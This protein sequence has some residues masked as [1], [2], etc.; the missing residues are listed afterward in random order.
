MR[1]FRPGVLVRLLYPDALFRM[2]GDGKSLCLTFDDGPDPQST[3]LLL[4]LLAGRDLRAIFFCTGAA[5]EKYPGLISLI[6][7]GGHLI[8]NHGYL[9][10]DGWRV[11]CARYVENAERAAPFTS[12]RLFRPP[13]GHLSPAQFRRLSKSYKIVFWDI[14]PYD[15][16]SRF[17]PGNSLRT[18]MRL[19]RPGAVIVLHD[20]P[21]SSALLFLEEFIDLAEAEGYNFKFPS[22]LAGGRS[23]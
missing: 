11:S 3:P 9:H 8:G 12:A 1:F 18:L 7:A 14:M 13:Y 22:Y 4:R 21:G 10:L 23:C 17:G 19:I 2:S 5:A 15:F 16:D 20:R 6:R